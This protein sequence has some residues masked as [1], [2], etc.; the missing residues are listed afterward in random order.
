[1]C[2]LGKTAGATVAT[3]RWYFGECYS[4]TTLL[5]WLEFRWVQKAC[6]EEKDGVGVFRGLVL[7]EAAGWL[8]PTFVCAI[9]VKKVHKP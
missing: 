1:M 3:L 9:W 2:H 5:R 6:F 7:A 8:D 4:G